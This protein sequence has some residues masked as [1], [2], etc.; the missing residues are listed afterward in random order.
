MAAGLPPAPEARP[1]QQRGMR[2]VGRRPTAGI[3]RPRRGCRPWLCRRGS[4]PWVRR[5]PS[6]GS[7]GASPGPG[8]VLTFVTWA[9]RS[10]GTGHVSQAH[11][12][13]AAV[14]GTRDRR[15]GGSEPW[16]LSPPGL[17]SAAEGKVPQAALP[18]GCGCVRP[19]LLQRVC[20]S[21]PGARMPGPGF[22]ATL[23]SALHRRRCRTREGHPALLGT[24]DS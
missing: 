3:S 19:C 18:R 16:T 21:L 11:G 1:G 6:T 20:L 8:A 14:T 4:L 5:C 2:S 12:V 10:G 17:G 23:S 15:R 7:C 24:P 22:W 9:P 13:G